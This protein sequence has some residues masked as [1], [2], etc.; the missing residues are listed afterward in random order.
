MSAQTAA[1]QASADECAQ[2]PALFRRLNELEVSAHADTTIGVTRLLLCDD[3]LC[4][5]VHAHVTKTS[6]WLL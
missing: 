5:D 1:G 3:N 6:I 2:L 4:F